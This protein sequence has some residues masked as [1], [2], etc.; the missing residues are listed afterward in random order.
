MCQLGVSL[1]PAWYSVASR[2][3]SCR[4]QTSCISVFCLAV[5]RASNRHGR[6][7]S[8]W[9]DYSAFKIP[10]DRYAFSQNDWVFICMW[11]VN[12]TKWVHLD[13]ISV[14]SQIVFPCRTLW[15]C[16]CKNWRGRG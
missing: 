7:A 15:S 1:C 6:Q 9:F 12:R 4:V 16:V 13:L 14:G 10:C 11:A 8:E 5:T 2:E 3:I